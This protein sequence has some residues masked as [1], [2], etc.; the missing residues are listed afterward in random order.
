MV[1]N[2]VALCYADD[3]MKLELSLVKPY[4]GELTSILMRGSVTKTSQ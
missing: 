1:I 4:L 3:Y 2:L